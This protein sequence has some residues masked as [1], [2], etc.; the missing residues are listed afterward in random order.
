MRKLY[1]KLLRDYFAARAMQAL[2]PVRI[3]NILDVRSKGK[4]KAELAYR[5]ADYMLEARNAENS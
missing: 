1:L 4:L 2:V 3:D 5:M